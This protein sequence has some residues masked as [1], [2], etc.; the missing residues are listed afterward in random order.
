MAK[1]TALIPGYGQSPRTDQYANLRSILESNYDKVH[2]VDVDWQAGTYVDWSSQANDA[3]LPVK[4]GQLDLVGYSMG[5]LLAL[6]CS[7]FMHVSRLSLLSVS[8]MGGLASREVAQSVGA[9]YSDR[10]LAAFE[11]L[12]VALMIRDSSAEHVHVFYGGQ[13]AAAM[14]ERSENVAYLLGE[15][16]TLAVIPSAGHDDALRYPYLDAVSASFSD[17]S[18]LP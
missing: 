6:D 16:A 18:V 5:G 7:S 14:Q 4:Q 13:E 11:R 10:E 12:V 3:L 9:T 1:E 15:R 2:L 8:S 17:Y